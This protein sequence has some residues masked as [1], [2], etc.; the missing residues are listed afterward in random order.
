MHPSLTLWLSAAISVTL[1]GAAR[2]QTP[3][4]PFMAPHAHSFIQT[5]FLTQNVY[6]ES[7]NQGDM[8]QTS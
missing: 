2:L 3:L 6:S 7:K 5:Q 4:S 8:T 1:T